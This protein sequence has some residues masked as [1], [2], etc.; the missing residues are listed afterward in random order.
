MSFM[1][2]S[3]Q[4][5]GLLYY[6]KSLHKTLL[7]IS[8]FCFFTSF[9]LSKPVS[10]RQKEQKAAEKKIDSKMIALKLQ[11]HIAGSIAK[12]LAPEKWGEAQSLIKKA[13][14][15]DQ[16]GKSD[17]ADQKYA[18]AGQ[19]LLSI[20]REHPFKRL[21]NGD[22]QLGHITLHKKTKTIS[23]PAKVAYHKEMPVEVI[24]SKPDAERSYETLFTSTMRP[25]HLQTMLY[26]A[27]YMNGSRAGGYKNSKQ[28]DPLKLS[29]RITSED[30]KKSITK[31]VEDFL[32]ISET[33]EPWKQKYWI[34]VGSNVDKGRLIADLTG[35]SVISWCVSPAII[36][37]SDEGVASGET[38]LDLVE[39]KEFP[40]KS[41][42]LFIISPPDEKQ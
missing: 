28:G 29:V 7:I 18:A 12:S 33:K 39:N 9:L 38:H 11:K 21:N 16:N 34:F 36:Q 15:A 14:A 22:M 4:H 32:C 42:I 26:L 25:L 23:F 6:W 37:P 13:A 30:G 31:P 5:Y 20:E 27:G 2:S 3:L 10:D 19:I 41:K 17:I 1:K 24:L 8:F 35:E 40:N